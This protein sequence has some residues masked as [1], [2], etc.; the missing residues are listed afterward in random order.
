MMLLVMVLLI[1]AG[2]K[3]R[4]HFHGKTGPDGFLFFF[5]SY[6]IPILL[7][8]IAFVQSGET[9]V[10]CRGGISQQDVTLRRN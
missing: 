8:E 2:K 7:I 9:S 3:T 5:F 10:P 1:A 6:V 4:K